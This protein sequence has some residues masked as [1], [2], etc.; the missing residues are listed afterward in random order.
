LFVNRETIFDHI[1]VGAGSAGCAVAAR[2][3]EHARVLLLE[4]GG[5]GQDLALQDPAQ[6]LAAAFAPPASVAYPT[7]AQP[8]LVQTL[9]DARGRSVGIHRGIV[10]GGS[11]SINGMVW[12][13][14]NR[15][16]FDGW[17]AQGCSGWSYDEVLPFFRRIE[18]SAEGA[19]P[20]HG[21]DGP[22]NVRPLPKPSAVA[23][24]F[25][26]AARAL[27]PFPESAPGHDYNGAV[28]NNAACL[29]RV[30]VTPDGRRASAAEAYL[31]PIRGRESLTV[32]TG[33]RVASVLV[34]NGRAVGV[35]CLVAGAEQV[36]RVASA[37]GEIVLSAGAFESP[38]L[39]LRS[40][41]G[42]ADELR[43]L[44]ITPLLDR[45]GVGRNLHDHLQCLTF[46]MSQQETGQS[47]FIAEAA[48]FTHAATRSAQQLPDLQF[49]F[50]AGLP[51]FLGPTWTPHFICCP[52]LLT[53]K[54]R[55]RVRLASA[56]PT[57]LPLVDPN[58]L[59]DEDDVQVLVHGLQLAR[60][61]AAQAPLSAFASTA[62]TDWFGLG[63]DNQ[64]L[65]VPTDAA[66]LAAFV[67]ATASTVWHPVGSC[68]MGTG[69]EAV[70]DPQ[71]RVH[72]VAG[73]RV[74]DAS[75]MPVIT[76]GNTNAPSIM[77]GERAADFIRQ[78]R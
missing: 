60:E 48:L 35:R 41:I 51:G 68:A 5:M 11:S 37:Q 30:N 10:R 50:L 29:Y 34:E 1:V 20:W 4:A 70:V 72:G 76:R 16:D 12:V 17:A 75:V 77:I 24:A 46:R 28:Q 66:A 36:F 25:V 2:L 63:A 44:G 21:S 56:D 22:V 45:P 32:K 61:L 58:Y 43:A 49:H 74:A 19:S 13:H 14:G 15:A 38:A 53:P 78:A 59:A 54:S 52:V 26:Q 57:A 42:P 65:P 69:P 6:V 33:V 47:G 8:G 23:Q 7:T 9:P 62:A 67:R 55:G 73:L 3:S 71:L 18:T 64:P 39:L 40:G 27:G 31:D